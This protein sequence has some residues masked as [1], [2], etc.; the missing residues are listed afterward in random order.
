MGSRELPGW[1]CSG[2]Q[3]KEAEQEGEVWG[4]F[5]T[6]VLLLFVEAAAASSCLP[7]GFL[8]KAPR[9]LRETR[10]QGG[11][12]SRRKL[13]WPNSRVCVCLCVCEHFS[14]L[15]HLQDIGVFQPVC[16]GWPRAAHLSHGVHKG[17]HLQGASLLSFPPPS[18]P[19]EE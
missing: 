2:E 9:V 4:T 10:G 17:P 1:Q 3:K 14:L 13:S 5:R 18:S 16:L 11:F 6:E 15:P 19:C 8:G 7:R 12:S